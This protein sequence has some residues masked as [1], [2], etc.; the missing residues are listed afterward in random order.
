MNKNIIIGIF[1]FVAVIGMVGIIKLS[2]Q[3]DK[4]QN[5][6]GKT[7]VQSWVDQEK[8]NPA[9]EIGENE[10][11][12]SYDN[13]A[14]EVTNSKGIIMV[15]MFGPS[16]PHCQKMGPIVSALA[17]EQKGKFRFAKLNVY[18]YTDFG[19]DYKLDGVPTFIVFKDGKEA[20]RVSGEQTKEKLLSM[21]TDAAK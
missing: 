9:A 4:T 20:S 12:L 5:S 6:S 10:V 13:F 16:C 3:P 8:N 11:R 21:L 14:T 17:K 15:D 2:Q 1:I 19:T 18:A 7:T